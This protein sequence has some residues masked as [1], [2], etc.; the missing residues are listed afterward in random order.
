MSCRS[1]SPSHL[2]IVHFARLIARI[3]FLAVVP[4]INRRLF[5]HYAQ[6]VSEP[7]CPFH[8]TVNRQSNGKLFYRTREETYQKNQSPK[9]KYNSAAFAFANSYMAEHYGTPET[10]AQLA[11]EFEAAHHIASNG[12]PY[13]TP[14]SWKFNSL[15]YDYKQSH[16]F[17]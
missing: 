5:V 15:Q 1:P 9:Q 10:K 14:W 13:K 2:Y 4:I 11:V 16:P 12:K 8:W 17:C 6:I 7:R 3:R